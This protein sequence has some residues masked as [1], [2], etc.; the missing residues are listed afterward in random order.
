MKRV[1]ITAG[2]VYGP[3]DANKLVG[4]RVRGLWA[5]QFA[6]Y[7]A[8][9]GH[10][11]VMLIPDTMPDPFGQETTPVA[12]VR[13]KGFW[14]YQ[15]KCGDLSPK[16]D[17]AV[18]A[19]A[20]VN[21]I[22]AQPYGGKMPT[23][24]YNE[25]DIIQIPFVLAPHVIDQMKVANPGLTLIGCKMLVNAPHDELIEAA[26]GVLIKAKCNAVVANDMGHG[27][28]Q[29]YVVNQDRSVQVYDNDFEGFYAN[30]LGH[31]EDVHYS[32]MR[33]HE[34]VPVESTR[35]LF[36]AV[37]EKHRAG[38]TP[39][40]DGAQEVF[41]S[42]FV[43]T[44]FTDS[45]LLFQMYAG[46]LSPREKGQMFTADE[47]VALQSLQGH[48]LRVVGRTKAT[49][50]APLLLR[51]AQKYPSASAILHQHRQ[52][53]DVP[54]VPYAPPGT[55]R[56]NEREIPGPVFNIEGHGFIACLDDKLEIFGG[57]P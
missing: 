18:M 9:R 46:L 27:L 30:L 31:I 20:V 37:I 19:A 5:T 32:T 1:L 44:M 28:K 39:R 33:Q 57:A 53:P 23:K 24:G 35:R 16:V 50:N 36:D 52:L 25:G 10:Q 54:T 8:D 13:H 3:L 49:L 15:E 7:L 4:N 47:A 12:I 43:P 38:F 42:V 14:D 21:W 51:V 22:P 55:V 41:G 17:A 45:G 29:K 2:P 48:L 6:K 40:Q 56:D 26:Y 34:D 11:V